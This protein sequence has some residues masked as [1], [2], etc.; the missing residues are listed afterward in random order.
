MRRKQLRI[1]ILEPTRLFPGGG[2]GGM[3]NIARHLSE[4]HKVTVFTQKF[5]GEEFNF[6]KSKV[7]LIKPSSTYLSNFAFLLCKIKKEDF[8]FIIYGCYPAAFAAFRSDSLPSLHI[9][10]SPPRAFYDLRD[11][12]F[13]NSNLL[14][15][16]KILIKCMKQ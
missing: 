2:R 4:K 15:K 16:I 11:Y 5:L 13:K 7:K 8:D 6:G 9:T 12:L 3:P 10:N 1:A 14:G